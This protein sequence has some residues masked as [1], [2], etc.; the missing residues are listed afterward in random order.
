MNK[1]Y[2]AGI[3]TATLLAFSPQLFSQEPSSDAESKAPRAPRH[4]PRLILRSNH[5]PQKV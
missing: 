2:L 3:L 4:L 1:K 5:R